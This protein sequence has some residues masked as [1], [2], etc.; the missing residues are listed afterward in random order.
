MQEFAEDIPKKPDRSFQEGH[1]QSATHQAYMSRNDLLIVPNFLL[2]ALPRS[3]RGDR[4]YYCCTMLTLFKP[5]HNGKDLKGEHSSWDK[6][7][8]AHEFT[9]QQKD[10]MK[11]FDVRYECL[12]GRDDYSAKRAKGD[13]GISYQWA[14]PDLLDK[15]DQLHE[16]ELGMAGADFGASSEYDDDISGIV[17]RKGKHR[18]N[19][20]LTAEQTMKTAGWLDACEDGLPDVGCLDPVR[21]EVNQPSKAWRAA[22][23]ARK[24]AVIEERNK[25]IP[26]NTA[27]K[28]INFK[29][30][31]VEIVD[32]SYID[33]LFNPT[34]KHD[35][36]LITDAIEKFILNSEQQRAFRIIA[37]HSVMDRP[38]QLKMYL[39][40]MGGTGKSQVIK[41]LTHFFGER[42]ENHRFLVVAPTGSAAALLN[43]FTYHSVLGIND[44]ERV[45]AASLAQIRA[46]LDGVDYIFLDEVSMISCRDMY[47]ISAQAAK[48]RGVYDEPFGGINFIFAGDFAQLPPARTG[49]TLYSGDVGTTVDA[50]KSID[51]QEAAIGKALWHQITT[52]VILRH[53]TGTANTRGCQVE[54]CIRKYEIQ[55]LYT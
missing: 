5:W 7:F 45:S 2:D 25:H 20:M 55:I 23:L 32:K 29:P 51:H 28:S 30:N 27:S 37:N 31:Q 35:D 40:G 16:A 3:D 50:G 39:G 46:R 33:H 38:D 43:G 48:A 42:K 12:D 10:I 44:G 53:E 9:R 26:T 22:V 1:P 24:Q 54:D 49:A 36:H 47:K 14:T 8:V 4:E 17:G 15:L 41:A 34:S 6:A 11:Y 18:L 21:P 13:N 52:V 19:E